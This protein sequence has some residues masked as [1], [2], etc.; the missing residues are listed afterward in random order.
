MPVAKERSIFRE[1]ADGAGEEQTAKK[2]SRQILHHELVEALDALERSKKRL[3]ASGLSGGLDIGFSLLLMAT[4]YSVAEGLVPKPVFEMLVASMYSIGFIFV[5]IGRSELFTEQTTLAVLPVLNGE[6]S[7]RS[8]LR[9]WV[10]VY[11]ANQ[12]GAAIFAGLVVLIGPS[13]KIIEVEA[14]GAIARSVVDHP[15]WVILL[16]AILAGWMMGLLTWLVA[17]G[18]DTISQIV[19]VAVITTAIGFTHLHHSV[20]GTVEVLAGVFSGQGVTIADFF[21]FLLW[22][23]LGNAIGGPVFVALIKYS[24]ARKGKGESKKTER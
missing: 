7:I 11:T 15:W 14:L 24:Y 5:V 13:L 23:S 1:A 16:S 22:A 6:A 19:I 2:A 18:R 12:L 20:V 21:H 3:F 4:M 8:L 10:L 17:A 9:L